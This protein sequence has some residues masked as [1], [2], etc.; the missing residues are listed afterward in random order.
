MGP[1]IS[2]STS[3]KIYFALLVLLEKDFLVFFPIIHHFQTS[4]SVQKMGGIP[5]TI[6]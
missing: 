5:L 4:K 6:V 1:H 2:E 3:S